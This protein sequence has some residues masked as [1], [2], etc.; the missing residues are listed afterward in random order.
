[1]PRA[2]CLVGGVRN[3]PSV[4]NVQ[5]SIVPFRG[6]TGVVQPRASLAPS[7]HLVPARLPMGDYSV[8]DLLAIRGRTLWVIPHCNE[9]LSGLT[10]S[11]KQLPHPN[12]DLNPVQETQFCQGCT[13]PSSYPQQQLPGRTHVPRTGRIAMPL[14]LGR[15]RLGRTLSLPYP[16]CDK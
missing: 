11:G 1:M 6:F 3:N 14:G 9:V 13:R 4:L 12:I 5:R 8:R 16:S 2:Y 15:C 10:L 7:G